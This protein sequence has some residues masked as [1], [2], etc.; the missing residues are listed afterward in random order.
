MTREHDE[1]KRRQAIQ[2]PRPTLLQPT[3]PMRINRL[4]PVERHDLRVIIRSLKLR[5]IIRRT[6]AEAYHLGE[7]QKARTQM[8]SMQRLQRAACTQ[9][10]LQNYERALTPSIEIPLHVK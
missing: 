9:E 1:W 3:L 10:S 4:N 8:H 7:A 2:V 6:L 5:K